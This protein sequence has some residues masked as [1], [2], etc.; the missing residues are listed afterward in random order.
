MCGGVGRGMTGA[1]CGGLATVGP[2]EPAWDIVCPCILLL[3]LFET[4]VAQ[5][6]LG[7]TM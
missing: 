3:F 4:L 7:L 1:A 6:V 5:V 2:V